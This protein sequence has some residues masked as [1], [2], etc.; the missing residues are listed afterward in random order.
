MESP[1][2]SSLS[3]WW[4]NLGLKPEEICRALRGI[5]AYAEPFRKASEKLE[6]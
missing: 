5:N 4:K 2:T 1:N 3:D 6:K